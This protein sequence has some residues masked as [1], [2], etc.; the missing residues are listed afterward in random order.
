MA[1]SGRFRLLVRRG[2]LAFVARARRFARSKHGRATGAALIV[3]AALTWLRAESPWIVTELQERTFDAYQ[4]LQPRT[5]ADFPVRIVDIDEA[6]IAA[7]G[8]WPWPR[9]RLA[10]ITNRLRSSAQAPPPLP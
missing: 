8:Q 4:R 10:A 1:S 9:S 5:Y 2:G 6:S 7:Y 3:L